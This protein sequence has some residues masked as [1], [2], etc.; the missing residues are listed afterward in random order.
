QRFISRAIM[1]KF[2]TDRRF[3]SFHQGRFSS[4]KILTVI[5]Q[6]TR[7]EFHCILPRLAVSQTSTF[8]PAL[9]LLTPR[10]SPSP[11][12]L[13]VRALSFVPRGLGPSIYGYNNPSAYAFHRGRSCEGNI[14]PLPPYGGCSCYACVN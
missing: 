9:R 6:D 1:V 5:R 3:S 8:V 7:V 4:G 13:L 10:A 12:V 14:S 11:A 2:C